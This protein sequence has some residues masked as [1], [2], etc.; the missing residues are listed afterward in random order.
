MVR[1]G[2]DVVCVRLIARSFRCFLLLGVSLFR[3]VVRILRL[4]ISKM[5]FALPMFVLY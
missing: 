2:L 5:G 4:S 3:L 1:I